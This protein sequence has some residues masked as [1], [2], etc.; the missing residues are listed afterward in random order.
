MVD[1]E[2]LPI[3][4]AAPDTVNVVVEVPVG[5]RNK[6][7]F[8][9][10]LGVVIRDRVLPGVVRYPMDYGFIPSTIADDGE[11]VDVILAAYDPAFPGCVVRARPIG[12]LEMQDASGEDRNV[13]AVPDD[14]DR[15]GDIHDVA[16][17][18]EAN[19]REISDFFEVYKQLE[20]DE[21]VQIHGWSGADDAHE[22]IRASARSPQTG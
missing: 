6:Y 15:F 16:D 4:D 12:V 20:G 21:Q 18:P 7:E 11:P 17:L 10:E 1:L 19:L 9:P 3:G 8:D 2:Q 5:S 13:I 14:D 22:L